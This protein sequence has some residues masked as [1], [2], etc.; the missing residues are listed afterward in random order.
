M[1]EKIRVNGLEILKKLDVV[2]RNST[3]KNPGWFI[4]KVGKN[5]ASID[6]R[7]AELLEDM[8]AILDV[9]YGENWQFFF[10]EER[11]LPK[12]IIRYPKIEIT[13]SRDDKH[14]IRDLIVI[15]NLINRNSRIN[16]DTSIRG[17]RLTVSKEELLSN[18]VHSH[19]YQRAYN[20]DS[21]DINTAS[22]FCLGH[23][24][25]PEVIAIFNDNQE[26]GTFELF[27]M[28]LNTMVEWESL[29]G[30]PYFR[31]KEISNRIHSSNIYYYVDDSHVVKATNI[32]KD[33]ELLRQAD[34]DMDLNKIKIVENDFLL[35]E[36]K[37]TVSRRHPEMLCKRVGDNYFRVLNVENPANFILNNTFKFKG[38]N[39]PFKIYNNRVSTREEEGNPFQIH[40]TALNI[41]ISRLNKYLY[42][43]TIAYCS[44]TATR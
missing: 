39:I 34:F 19:L 1:R 37:K 2:N 23:N 4:R 36:L 25:I 29:E 7:V 22:S 13:N 26:T 43:K 18:Y 11:E 6:L 33:K 32:L 14:T 28:T 9:M 5:F 44:R 17:L 21:L 38:E 15:I 12:I 27:L 16:I 41:S 24:E 10:Y 31:I 3:Y 40:P 20:D 30:T 42:E 8:R 35:G